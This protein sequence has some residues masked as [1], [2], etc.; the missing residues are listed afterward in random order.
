MIPTTTIM[1]AMT[2]AKTRE[3]IIPLPLA[4]DASA[5]AIV[6]QDLFLEISVKLPVQT[7][8]DS[9]RDLLKKISVMVLIAVAL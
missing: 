8:F 5:S 7:L 6:L 1:F 9:T 2:S 3:R 4:S